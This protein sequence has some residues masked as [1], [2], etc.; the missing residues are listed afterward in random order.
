MPDDSTALYHNIPALRL[1]L[2]GVSHLAFRRRWP[3]KATTAACRERVK[4]GRMLP[5]ATVFVHL[6]LKQRSLPF[7]GRV[8]YAAHPSGF[9]HWEMLTLWHQTYLPRLPGSV[10]QAVGSGCGLIFTW[11]CHWPRGKLVG[12][13]GQLHI[14]KEHTMHIC[15]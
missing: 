4:C 5:T 2:P 9:A 8:H 6:S 13:G 10:V 3:Q 15:W 14:L 11:A 7:I 1:P 12:D